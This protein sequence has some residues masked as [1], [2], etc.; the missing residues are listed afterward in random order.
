[1]TAAWDWSKYAVGGA[2]R[3]DS[4]TGMNPQFASAL[5]QMFAAAPANV[6]AQ[7]RVG[8]GFRDNA[9]QAQ[10]WEQALQK[11]GSPEKARKWV[12]PPGNSKHNHGHAADLKYLGDDAR[13]WAHA[14]ARQFGLAFPMDHEDWH[15]ELAGVRDGQPVL[16][17]AAAPATGMPTAA[18][19]MP[20]RA[21]LGD[22]VAPQ[23]PAP[24]ADLG[25]VIASILANQQQSQ[26]QQA[27]IEAAE[28]ARRQALFG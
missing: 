17:A 14:N 11:Y 26:Q 21:L 18:P 15:V 1:M 10:L 8:S 23:P 7:L 3:P 6:Q 12:A 27:E 2:T 4:F 5:Q 9:R 28:K 13:T 16:P 25:S 22:A 19:G 20:M 24:R